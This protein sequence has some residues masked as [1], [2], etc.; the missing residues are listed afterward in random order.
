MYHDCFER[1]LAVGHVTGSAWI[2]DRQGT[3]TL[4]AHHR[5]LDRWMQCGGHADGESDILGVALRE[6]LEESGLPEL[7]I[8]SRTIYDIDVHQI[9]GRPGE[10]AHEHFDVRYVLFGDTRQRPIVSRESKAVAWVP[11]SQLE[12]YGAD[13]SVRRMAAKTQPLIAR[14]SADG[15]VR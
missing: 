4:L 6:A 12:R 14:L 11:L 10:P 3:H 2:V 1:T 5:K 7:T 9:P 8:A 15:R 13:D